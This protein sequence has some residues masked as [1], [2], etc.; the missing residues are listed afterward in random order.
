MARI[1]SLDDVPL[2][3]E[4]IGSILI[5]AGYDFT[6][7]DDS[8]EAWA[9]LQTQPFDLLTQ[10]H[11]RPAIRGLDFYQLLRADAQLASMPVIMI[12]A[13]AKPEIVTRE[14][15]V[16][17]YI[18]KPF[19]PQALQE[20]IAKVLRA[21][22][23][24]VPTERDETETAEWWVLCPTRKIASLVERLQAAR[25]EARF[26]ATRDLGL[27]QTAQAIDPLLSALD[28]ADSKVRW[29]AAMG[30]GRRRAALAVAPLCAALGDAAP[31]VRMMAAHALGMIGAAEAA[32]PLVT[33]L[34]AHL[35]D[36]EPWERL[37][38]LHALT[39]ITAPSALPA[40]TQV[41]H[42][43]TLLE[44]RMASNALGKIGA[45]ALDA[46]MSQLD[47]DDPTMRRI[48]L[49]ALR[50]PLDNPRVIQAL[51]TA[52]RDEDDGVRRAA[53]YALGRS[54]SPRAVAPLLSLLQDPDMAL[55]KT[56]ILTL[57]SLADPQAIDPL[58]EIF[59]DP[60][61]PLRQEAAHALCQIGGRAWDLLET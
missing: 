30:L 42:H 9:L 54:Q 49:T 35:D 5:Q 12:T 2:M 20:A 22:D 1:L 7:T 19:G 41:L 48:A 10:D 60:T 55:V 51:A 14:A 59:R 31:L 58:F 8:F 50:G 36:P 32:K 61:H 18:I 45:P 6:Y 17:E 28:D 57:G 26:R 56:T 52:L 44:K 53:V 4:A 25:P 34:D 16:D 13:Y 43:H 27:R 39:Q 3:G 11:M 21:R 38:V 40:L 23:I 37:S 15:G 47:A 33:Y 46:L 24:P 29:A